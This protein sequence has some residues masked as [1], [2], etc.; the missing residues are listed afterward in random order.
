[1]KK[2]YQKEQD[3]KRNSHKMCYA[4]E[5]GNQWNPLKAYPRNLPCPCGSGIKF[6]KCCV[7]KIPM[8]VKKN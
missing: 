2:E 7:D 5:S 4:L 8:T 3:E 1:M 6:K